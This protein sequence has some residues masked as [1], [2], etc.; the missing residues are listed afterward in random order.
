[1]YHNIWIFG[2]IWI[3]SLW[4]SICASFCWFFDKKLICYSKLVLFL[5]LLCN[6]VIFWDW[7]VFFWRR[8][9]GLYLIILFKPIYL[10]IITHSY[11][12]N[13]SNIYKKKI[14]IFLMQWLII[15]LF[16]LYNL[17]AYNIFIL[18]C[19]RIINLVWVIQVDTIL[20]VFF[21]NLT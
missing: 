18:S 20:N 16:V 5:F 12:F 14:L 2:P 10:G 4:N 3:S 19:L 9:F 6:E 8:L 13:I 15:F 17:I 7:R 11:F 21:L 1:M